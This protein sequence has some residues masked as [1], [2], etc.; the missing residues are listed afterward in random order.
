[1]PASGRCAIARGS[2]ARWTTSS[3]CSGPR[4]PQACRTSAGAWRVAR[5]CRRAGATFAAPRTARENALL[6]AA[7]DGRTVRL[8]LERTRATWRPLDARG[9]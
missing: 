5:S 8:G 4:R 6:A 9:A 2:D 3:R 7:A 1:V